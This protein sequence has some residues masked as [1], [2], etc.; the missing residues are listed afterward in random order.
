MPIFFSGAP[1]VTPPACPPARGT[2]TSRGA[3]PATV[4][5]NSSQK[6]ACGPWLIQ[7]LVPVDDVV[8]AVAHR[9]RRDRR[10]HRIRPAARTGR[11]RRAARH[12]AC[13][14]A[15]VAL[16]VVG[17]EACQR[18]RRQRVH[19]DVDGDA[20]PGGRDLLQHLQVD[21]VR[22]S[23]AA[24][25]SSNGS[26]SSPVLPSRVNTS[27][28]NSASASAWSTRGASCSVAISRTSVDQVV[29]LRRRQQA[30]DSHGVP[31][32]SVST[33][34]RFGVR[35]DRSR[36]RDP[37][38]DAGVQRLR[39]RGHRDPHQHV[40]RLADQPRQALALAA[41]DQHHRL[42]RRS[43]GRRRPRRRRHRGRRPSARPPGT[44]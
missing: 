43:P 32:S 31:Q 22:L 28:G 7:A 36:K 6:S 25:S 34:V 40:T 17:A 29:G 20:H 3:R 33:H 16:L 42:G 15:S 38:R 4:R 30:F 44:P 35:A 10:R 37:G 39:R 9:L 24:V 5:A 18:R 8:V 11:R 14:A 27:R 12:R 13:R 19:R 1:N 41:D 26:D 23:A 21:L 2:P